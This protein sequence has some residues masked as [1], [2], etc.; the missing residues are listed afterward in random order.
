MEQREKNL[1]TFR[2]F[3]SYS[4]FYDPVPIH[5][6]LANTDFYNECAI[7]LGRM[8]QHQEALELYAYQMKNHQS[9]FDYCVNHSKGC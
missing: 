6:E 3:L 4:K 7:V 8:G 2:D 1:Q 9:A 5:A